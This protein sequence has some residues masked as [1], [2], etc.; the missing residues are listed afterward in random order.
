MRGVL[1]F[2]TCLAVAGCYRRIEN[3]GTRTVERGIPMSNPVQ[4]VSEAS[5][6]DRRPALD[7]EAP[8]EFSTATFALG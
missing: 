4:E 7:R 1:C 2:L 5:A 3:G 6:A 8:K